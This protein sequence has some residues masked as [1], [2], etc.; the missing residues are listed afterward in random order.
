MK[1]WTKSETQ[2]IRRKKTLKQNF[3][4]ESRL[5]IWQQENRSLK[6]KKKITKKSAKKK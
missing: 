6:K 2:L 1:S 3:S 4:K 5:N